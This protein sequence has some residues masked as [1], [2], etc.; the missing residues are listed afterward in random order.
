MNSE[1]NVRTFRPDVYIL[2]CFTIS[3]LCFT[4]ASFAFGA[5]PT[6]QCADCARQGSTNHW[7]TIDCNAS[8]SQCQNVLLPN[9]SVSWVPA[10]APVCKKL[11]PGEQNDCEYD[12]LLITTCATAF[13]W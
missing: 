1:V 13:Y 10:N 2:V 12:P 4:M 5:G 11:A 9:S 8:S 3:L 7:C 6:W